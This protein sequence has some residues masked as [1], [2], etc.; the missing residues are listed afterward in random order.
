MFKFVS[1]WRGIEA[2]LMQTPWDIYETRAILMVL[3]FTKGLNANDPYGAV[4]SSTGMISLL[5]AA[6]ALVEQHGDGYRCAGS[7]Y[8][9]RT[10]RAI[11]CRLE[12]L[13]KQG[14]V[15]AAALCPT[16]LSPRSLSI[17]TKLPRSSSL[18]RSW[19]F[20]T[21]NSRPFIHF[22]LP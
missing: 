12:L 4:E 3:M 18:R 8:A 9:F 14:Q 22:I 1:L 19:I 17:P 13:A 15:R 16:C 6:G 11:A 2:A 5:Q 10:P 20:S 7:N 21:L